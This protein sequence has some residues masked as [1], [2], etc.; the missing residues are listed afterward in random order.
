MLDESTRGAI[1]R[2]AVEGHG[3]R[4][5]ARLLGIAR[6]TVK[7][8]MRDGRAEVPPLDR[9]EKAEPYRT[10]ILEQFA[11]CKGNLVRVHEE[12]VLAGAAMS[13]QALTAFCR[14]HGI[15]HP[16]P[17]PSGHYDFKPGEEMQ[18]DTSPHQADLGGRPRPVVTASLVPCYSRM[19]FFQMYPRFT[20]FECKLFLTDALGYYEGA[21]AKNMIDNTHVIVASGTG[22]DM[23]PAPEMAAFAERYDFEWVAH[24][25]GDA[26]RSARVERP[27]DYIE[28]NFL[29]GRKFSDWEDLNRQAIV[30]CD[31]VN[32]THRRHL[33]AS[34]RELFV[35]ERAQ[36]KR[37]PA[38]VPEVYALHHRIVDTEG[39][40]N[41]HR[42]RYSA[43]WK[44]IG[45]QVEVRETKERIEI[46]EGPRKLAT[47]PRVLD[48]LDARTTDP[49][50]RPPRHEGVFAR[51]ISK[52]E[53]RLTARMPEM[54]PYLALLKNR[55]RGTTRDLRWLLRMIDDYPGG[56][57]RA[58]LGEATRYG[59]TDLERF[60]RMVLRR[61][62]QNFFAP[63]RRDRRDDPPDETED[64]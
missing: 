64:A 26:N 31:K 29:A 5:I 20:R 11:A 27:F 63:P 32:A 10:Q 15:G 37:L 36:M 62:V 43:P 14:R 35:A 13:Y 30:W 55:G 61:I 3:A 54:Q 8:V 9:A 48:P 34:P 50:H 44:L 45:R 46:F 23:V 12:L 33:H 1:L 38:W 21:C 2:L 39:Y 51:R 40:V 59:M 41:V 52:E 7:R 25:V 24:E 56:A 18:H 16:P 28:N 57:V 53:Q 4:A 60:E 22:R 17:Q 42:N 19:L 6:G 49:T 47:H 58:A